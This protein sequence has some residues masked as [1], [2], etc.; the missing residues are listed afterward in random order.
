MLRQSLREIASRRCYQSWVAV[1]VA[2]ALV[3]T[4]LPLISDIGFEFAFGMGLLAAY[5]SGVVSAV[6]FSSR[7]YRPSPNSSVVTEIWPVLLLN[8][9][10]LIPPFLIM[11]V[12]SLMSGLCNYTE[13][14]A[15][16]ILIPVIT[17]L[18]ATVLGSVC[19]LA[20][21]RPRRAWI[22][23][24]AYTLAVFVIDI[25]RLIT[26]PPV[27]AY[28]SI[29]GYFPGPIYDEIVRITDTLLIARGIVLL[30][31]IA[32]VAG[33]V[34]SVDP[35]SWRIHPRRLFQRLTRPEDIGRRA[36]RIWFSTAL[37]GLILA[38]V[39]GA[40]LGIIINRKHI[41]ETLGG[42]MQTEHFDIYYDIQSP[43]AHRV[44]MIARD[45]E[46]QYAQLVQYLEVEPSQRIRSF[47]YATPDQKKRL[48]GARFT[49]VE[50]PGDDEMHLN[51][52]P[53]PHP[54]LKHELAHVLSSSFGNRLYGGS[55]MMGYHEGLASAAD[56][57]SDQMTPHQWSRAMRQLGLSPPLEDILDT[58]GFWSEAPSRAY[59][60]CGS[61][62]RFL[63]DRYGIE[64][65]KQAFPD[66]D[67]EGAYR[68]PLV[69]LIR[70]WETFI[71]EITL[72]ER[73]LRIARQRFLRAGIFQRH[74]PHE[75]A[76]LLDYANGQY[77]LGR[78]ANAM[79]AYELVR[80]YEPDNASALRGLMFA[81][82]RSEDLQK[83]DD[84]A[85]MILADMNRTV[86][87]L[88]AAYLK[89][90]DLAWARGDTARAK[91]R[92][93]QA[94]ELHAGD[95]PDREALIKLAALN[96]PDIADRIIGYL[97]A[98]RDSGGH[99][100][101]V[102]EAIEEVPVFGVGYYLIGRRFFNEGSYDRALPYFI[103]A[104]SL[105]L[106]HEL[107]MSENRRLT[108]ESYFYTG[109]YDQAVKTFEQMVA[110][111]LSQAV[112]TRAKNW[113]QRCLWFAEQE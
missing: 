22:L 71:D 87:L 105:S 110:T 20:T 48:M 102:Q 64:R 91:D 60:L 40:S 111:T 108:G 15:F 67:V 94:F 8:L 55:Y 49:S 14:V 107:L 73:E 75:V 103:R 16:F 83:A 3:M 18:L 24:V 51:D 4:Q 66:G 112:S 79:R 36:A 98:D 61:F 6:H 86:G 38:Y 80:K 72:S 58:I 95:G 113:I 21:S 74:C 5:A 93:Q 104:D 85:G 2:A 54:V 23:F 78:Y 45:H 37:A 42:Y 99:M 97:T 50:R 43:T 25:Y 106:P 59:T 62:V 46:F 44:D 65:F 90:G 31:S 47:I 92:F 41:Q 76:S 89:Q 26:E 70:E 101:L 82:Y 68:T 63:I 19:G 12:Q 33:L 53:F 28:N 84:L 13:G 52:S 35:V 56:W 96:Q 1:L 88:T 81:A 57:R 11:S 27:F 29:I 34:L 77:N 39:Y 100:L 32:I 17:T 9:L 30:Q 69:T 7:H 109:A 10:T